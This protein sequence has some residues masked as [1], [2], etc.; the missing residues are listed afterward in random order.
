MRSGRLRWFG[1]VQRRDVNNVTHSDGPHS[2]GATMT[3]QEDVAQ[4]DQGRH[5]GCGC[6]PGCGPRPE[7]VEKKYKA[8]P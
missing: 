1:H 7:G 6:Y 5:D 4:T 8:D 3:A 2:T